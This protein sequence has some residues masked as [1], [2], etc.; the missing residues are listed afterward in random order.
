MKHIFFFL[1]EI[2]QNELMS[3]KHRKVC[4][5]LHYIEHFL[6]LASTI[7]ECISILY[8]LLSIPVGTTSSRIV[9]NF[10]AITAGIKKYKSVI[11][12]KEEE[13]R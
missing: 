3:K 13:T 12:K 4:T 7:T 6:I 8:F 9:L 1:K 2:V 10:F 5:T 11:K